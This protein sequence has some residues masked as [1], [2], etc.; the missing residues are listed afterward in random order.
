MAINNSESES[1]SESGTEC[2]S[3]LVFI[4]NM[5]LIFGDLVQQDNEY[6]HL[7]MLL[8]HIV[9]IVFSPALTDGMTILPE[10]HNC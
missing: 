1:E 3:D 2:N 4:G 7:L 6:W 9:N 5:P 8:L 10:K